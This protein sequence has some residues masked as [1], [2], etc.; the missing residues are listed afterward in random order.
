MIYN[1][2]NKYDGEWKN[3]LKEGE[4]KMTYNNGDEYNGYWEN[5]EIKKSNNYIIC[6]YNIK[7]D[8]LNQPIQILN[9]Y[10]EVKRKY[11]DWDWR[12]IK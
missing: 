2:G 10:E 4:G 9:S 3:D 6:E 11:D 5:D 12:N 1:N 7:K 8:K